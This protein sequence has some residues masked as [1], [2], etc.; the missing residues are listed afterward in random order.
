MD[1]HKNQRD[2]NRFKESIKDLSKWVD[3]DENKYIEEYRSTMLH[4][5]QVEKQIESLTSK[6]ASLIND[7]YNMKLKPLRDVKLDVYEF[8]KHKP[9]KRQ[10]L[11]F[12]FTE[13]FIDNK[14]MDGV[15]SELWENR[16]AKIYQYSNPYEERG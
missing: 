12:L 10:V 15:V 7:M 6:R 16:G 2:Y 9:N 13:G 8:I 5:E 14:V 4:V 1:K 3:I 11:D